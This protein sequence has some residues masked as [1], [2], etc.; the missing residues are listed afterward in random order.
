MNSTFV[1]NTIDDGVMHI[2]V[3]RQD[4]LNAVNRIVLGELNAAF[5]AAGRNPDVACIVLTGAGNRA[6]VAGADIGE[7]RSLDEDGVREIVQLGHDLMALIENLGKPVI[8][9]INGFALGAGCELTLACTLRIAASTAQIGL[10]EIHLGLMPG[11]GGTQRLCRLIGRSRALE[12]MLT[13]KPVR[14]EQ[15]MDWGLVHA[16]AEPEDLMD[17]VNKFAAKLAGSAPCAM[18]GILEAVHHGADLE[19]TRAMAIEA[20]QFISLFDTEDMREGT[21]AFL[22]KRKP[23]F[24]GR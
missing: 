11:Y 9:A 15:A 18:R 1:L 16:L 7:I 5:E 8:A 10:P 4:K 23:A 3:D 20:E 22:E 6:F 21:S 12:M 24:K 13:G 14:A 19:L 17:E 2:T